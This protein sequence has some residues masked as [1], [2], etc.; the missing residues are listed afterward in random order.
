MNDFYKLEAKTPSGDLLPMEQFRGKILLIANTATRCGLTPQLKGLEELHK[1]YKN[2]GLNVIGFPCNQFAWQEPL[3][4]D[5]MEKACFNSHRITFQLTEKI[6]V[7]GRNT[8]PIYQ[9]LK[10]AKKGFIV[11][12]IQWNFTKFLI[13]QQGN[14]IN[15]YAPRVLPKTIE[16]DIQ[17]LLSFNP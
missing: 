4:N 2:Y 1:T 5:N 12:S 16:N 9:F 6:N 11:S 15:R 17:Q 3:S 13:D 8:H 14:V 10:K 7:N